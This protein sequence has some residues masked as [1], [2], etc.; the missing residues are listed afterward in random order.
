MQ[1]V[2]RCW[3]HV[4]LCVLR[5]MSPTLALLLAAATPQQDV[6]DT[7]TSSPAGCSLVLATKCPCMLPRVLTT[8]LV[9]RGAPMCRKASVVRPKRRAS[10]QHA[11]GAAAAAAGRERRVARR[12]P[13]PCCLVH[14]VTRRKEI[15]EGHPHVTRTQGSAD[16]LAP[17]L[18]PAP[19]CLVNRRPAR[20]RQQ[21]IGGISAHEPRYSQLSDL[22]LVS[23]AL[24]V[25]AAWFDFGGRSDHTARRRSGHDVDG[26]SAVITRLGLPPAAVLGG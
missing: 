2:A 15:T 9:P 25:C 8:P 22:P 21:L 16:S 6:S 24:A 19:A 14:G 11:Q 10:T 5:G 17:V 23:A 3:W 1:N 13:G 12:V 20:V 26:G 18:A 7:T 4:C